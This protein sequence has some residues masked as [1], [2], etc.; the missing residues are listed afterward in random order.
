MA[1]KQ[2]KFIPMP[3][4]ETLA[5]FP[6]GIRDLIK[7]GRSQGFIT[8][9]EL[10]RVFPDAEKEIDILDEAFDLFFELG[11]EVLDVKDQMIWQKK[12]EEEDDVNKP[13]KAINLKEISNDSVRM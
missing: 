4:D 6:K 5:Q 11:I 1:K 3:S 13:Q 8:N 2:R 10:M 7:K 9:Q 12:E